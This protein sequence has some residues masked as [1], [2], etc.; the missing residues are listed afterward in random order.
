[1]FALA[2][3]IHQLPGQFTQDLQADGATIDTADVASVCAHLATEQ[4][5]IRTIRIVQPLFFQELPNDGR[6]LYFRRQ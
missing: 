5:P 3:D 2:M 4:Q 6:R 1:M